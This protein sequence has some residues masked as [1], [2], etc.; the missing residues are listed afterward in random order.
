MRI[1][2]AAD[3]GRE[4]DFAWTHPGEPVSLPWSWPG[5]T[6]FG[7]FVGIDSRRATTTAVVAD[8]VR[9]TV[10]ILASRLLC[11]FRAS[12]GWPGPAE[13]RP[14]TAGEARARGLHPLLTEDG[15]RRRAWD[16][17]GLLAAAA[18]RFD[19]GTLVEI[20]PRME[21]Q[22]AGPVPRAAERPVKAGRRPTPEP[23]EAG[24]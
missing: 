9:L 12:G 5:C 13:L 20:G 18:A 21:V 7:A 8:D 2:V 14:L 11:S 15:Q 4:G 17:A 16:E 22:P 3:G 6:A 10:E 23:P 1:L 24:Q 19:A